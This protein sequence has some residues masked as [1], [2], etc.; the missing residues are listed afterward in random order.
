MLENRF[1]SSFQLLISSFLVILVVILSWSPPVEAALARGVQE[2]VM[3]VLQIPLQILS[4]TFSGPPV[5]GT[6]F[7][8]VNGVVRGLGLVTH[9]ALELVSSGLGIAKAAAPFVLPFLF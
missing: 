8:A 6:A 2:V 9:G 4:G 3:G 1:R 7:G 5:V